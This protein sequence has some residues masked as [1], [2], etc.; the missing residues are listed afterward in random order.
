[1]KRKTPADYVMKKA[2]KASRGTE[3]DTHVCAQQVGG[4]QFELVIIAAQR[5]RDLARQHR[6]SDTY[7][8]GVVE[9][10]LEIQ[11]GEIGRDYVYKD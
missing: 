10:L 8:K 11:A 9:A 7:V 3:V 2:L 1:M 6:K 5:A 4:S